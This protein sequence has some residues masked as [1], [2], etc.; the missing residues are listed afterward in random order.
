M[1]KESTD[2]NTNINSSSSQ[3][4]FLNGQLEPLDE[5]KKKYSIS[6]PFL[7]IIF[8]VLFLYIMF[9]YVILTSKKY[10]TLYHSDTNKI[11]VLLN[12]FLSYIQIGILII[13]LVKNKR[14][15]FDIINKHFMVTC[16]FYILAFLFCVYIFSILRFT[17][18]LRN[19]DEYGD[20]DF[21][22]FTNY[23]TLMQFVPFILCFFYFYKFKN[24]NME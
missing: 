17:Y 2:T 24:I 7:I 5:N 1:E 16:G 8:F 21:C 22:F 4:I 23:Y 9:I 18:I 12:V 3:E 10:K 15:I 6:M 14:E 20:K 19:I 13:Y 11:I